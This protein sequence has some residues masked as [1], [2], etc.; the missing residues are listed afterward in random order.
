MEDGYLNF[1]REEDVNKLLSSIKD[2]K[3]DIKNI[4]TEMRLYGKYHCPHYLGINVKIE[5]GTGMMLIVPID[6]GK[7]NIKN[8]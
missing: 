8:D 4:D 3:L 2:G 6:M 7:K 1:Y 5:A